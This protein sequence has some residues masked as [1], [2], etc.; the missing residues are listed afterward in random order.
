MKLKLWSDQSGNAL[1]FAL[2]PEEKSASQEPSTT[3]VE[4]APAISLVANSARAMQHCCFHCTWCEGIISLPHDR[5]GLMFGGPAIRRFNARSVATVCGACGHVGGYSLFRGCSGFDTR[6]KLA[7]VHVAGIT[8]LVDLLHCEEATCTSAL[9]LF[10]T[11][12]RALTSGAAKDLAKSWDWENLKCASGHPVRT[13]EWVLYA[14]PLQF[15][16]E[17]K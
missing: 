14:K 2:A 6:H 4:V 13:P 8:R 9:P 3:V 5:L 15:P 12:E 1:V 17:L 10:V 7:T 16:A 11:S